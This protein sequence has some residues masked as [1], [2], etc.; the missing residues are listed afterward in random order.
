MGPDWISMH[1]AASNRPRL[2]DPNDPVRA[3]VAAAL[4]TKYITV[5]PVLVDGAHMPRP[6][7]LP[8]D[9]QALASCEAIRLSNSQ[10]HDDM[11][12][13]LEAIETSFAVF[14]GVRKPLRV[15]P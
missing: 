7:D 3:E 8:P 13:L 15:S 4:R 14:A 9:V 11:K 6:G 12:R 10:W 2:N 5:I 1:D